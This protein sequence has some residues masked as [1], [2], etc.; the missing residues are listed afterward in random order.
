MKILGSYLKQESYSDRW[1]YNLEC[2]C[3]KEFGMRQAN[4]NYQLKN[5]KTIS[6]GC[7]SQRFGDGTHKTKY[8]YNKDYFKELTPDSAYILG[9]LLTDGNMTKNT[10]D[11]TRNEIRLT[12]HSDDKYMLETISGLIKNDT[13]VFKKT[14]SNCYNLVINQKDIYQDL[15]NWGLYPNKS[16]TITPHK[17]LLN[18]RDFWR[19]C[20][21]GDGSL[22]VYNN[23]FTLS[24][25]GTK[26]MVDSFANYC[27]NLLDEEVMHPKLVK[28]D[29]SFDFYQMAIAGKKAKVI[30]NHLYEPTD[31]LY[32][33]R[34]YEIGYNHLSKTEIKFINKLESFFKESIID[35]L[36]V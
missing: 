23:S 2:D 1:W 17:D 31:N 32:L 34:K 6:C 27:N 29:Y 9:L 4:Y 7:K 19:G 18:S 36:L 26:G 11:K 30:F 20:V 5:G 8:A 21:D 12:L 3:G 16:S 25:C 10:G 15:L 28:G 14:D 35:S 13:T 22:G 24:M 33:K